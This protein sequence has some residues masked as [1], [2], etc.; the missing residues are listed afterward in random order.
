MTAR[1]PINPLQLSHPHPPARRMTWGGLIRM[2]YSSST[3]ARRRTKLLILISLIFKREMLCSRTLIALIVS[4]Y[5]HL[6]PPS[7]QQNVDIALRFIPYILP[8]LDNFSPFGHV[9]F[10]H[11]IVGACRPFLKN[12]HPNVSQFGVKQSWL[13]EFQDLVYAISYVRK[14]Q[15]EPGDVGR[16]TLSHQMKY[17]K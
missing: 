12:R 8:L 11:V 15:K 7:L 14:K 1:R 6:H 16:N 4:H 17:Y 2:Q 5:C 9:D 13:T 10:E 3:I